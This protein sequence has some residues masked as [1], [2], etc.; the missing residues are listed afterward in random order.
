MKYTICITLATLALAATVSA[1]DVQYNYDNGTDFA[2][3]KT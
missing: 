2:N 3:F 1:Q